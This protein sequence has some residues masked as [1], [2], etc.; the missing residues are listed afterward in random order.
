M[1]KQHGKGVCK[2][3]DEPMEADEKLAECSSSMKGNG[4][5]KEKDLPECSSAI[6]QSKHASK[7]KGDLDVDEE[8]PECSASMES[9]HSE[10]H[11]ENLSKLNAMSKEEILEQQ[12]Q[13]LQHMDPKLV[14]LVR[15]KRKS[16]DQQKESSPPQKSSK[17]KTP[18]KVSD[19]LPVLDFL[20]EEDASHWVHFDVLEPEKLEWTKSIKR[21][22]A[23]LKP[24]ESYEARFDWKGFLLPYIAEDNQ[25]EP[26]SDDRE[27]YLH[28]EDPQR[29][30]YTLQEFFRL[31]RSTVLQQRIAAINAIAGIINI[32]NQGYYDGIIELPISKIFF[33]LRFAL[34]EK[35]PQIIEASSRA[36][37][38]LFYN[39]TDETLLDIAYETKGGL[40]QPML[41]NQKATVGRWA[42]DEAETDLESSLKN[43]SLSGGRKMFE[44][45]IED[46][47][48][49]DEQD[50]DSM[51]DYHLAETDLI[52]CLKRTNI[53]NRI[54]YILTSTNPNDITVN[55][56]LKILI[57]I[58]RT[59]RFDALEILKK[60]SLI[61]RM[62]ADYLPDLEGQR[63]PHYIVLKLFRVLASYDINF[64]LSLMKSKLF[65]ILRSYVNAG[66]NLAVNRLKVQIESFRFLRLHFYYFPDE[67]TFK[68]L[69]NPIK[70][71]LTWQF[72]SMEFQ[73]DNHFIIR[74]HASAL[75]YLLGCGNRVVTF[76]ELGELFNNCCCKWFAMA[77]R[78][79]AKEFSQKLLLSTLLN[80]GA[81]FVEFSS[82]FFHKFVETYLKQFLNSQ[83]YKDMLKGLLT[84]TPFFKDLE[85]RCNVHKPLINLGSIVRKNKASVP[86]L[87]LSQDYSVYFLDSLLI[88]I[89]SFDNMNHLRNVE[90]HHWFCSV[91]YTEDVEKYFGRFSAKFNKSL[92][93]NWFLKTEINFIYNL[94][95][96]RAMQFSPWLLKVAFNLLNCLT[97][98]NLDK[99]NSIFKG[100]IFNERHY[101]TDGITN[102]EFERWKYIYSGIVMTDVGA[103]SRIA[104]K[105]VVQ[106]SKVFYF[107]RKTSIC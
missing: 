7:A 96:A 39:D 88:F 38:Y 84:T 65:E 82:E 21:T 104:Q 62:I 77:A 57:R 63:V 6:K 43:M 42:K 74:Q 55:S 18:P 83:H 66:T 4:A 19:D 98:E 91:F 17:V 67:H 41:Q 105:F 40:I 101:L 3:Q 97:Q 44:C 12:A 93:T 14:E 37:S 46:V 34:D 36:L 26:V 85:D 58:A 10:L 48:D 70:R 60:A 103:V 51:I 27:L 59:S 53:L 15:S 76:P 94:L 71:L 95:R 35:I 25:D 54:D 107:F 29:P 99:I 2:N 68:E 72:H 20:K 89:D 50:K 1:I 13:L 8:M 28:G 30:G 49:E 73:Q 11:K 56:C 47:I 64:S 79:G 9:L 16:N 102:R 22:M 106:L 69:I 32:Y 86:N 90:Y 52:A 92:A 87:V 5:S 78:W 23:K 31:G 100:F 80:V 24:D 75:I 61:E 81:P 33:F 45:K